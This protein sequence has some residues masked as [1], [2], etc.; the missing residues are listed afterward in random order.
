M[1]DQLAALDCAPYRG[2]APNPRTL[3][4]VFP[5]EAIWSLGIA[6]HYG[7]ADS[8]SVRSYKAK[9]PGTVAATESRRLAQLPLSG[10]VPVLVDGGMPGPAAETWVAPL[11]EHA[12]RVA[13]RP[14]GTVGKGKRF[15]DVIDSGLAFA[16][17]VPIHPPPHLYREDTIKR[18]QEKLQALL[19]AEDRTVAKSYLTLLVDHIVVDD[20][21]ITVVAKTEGALRRLA[22]GST[23]DGELTAAVVSP[24][25]VMPWLG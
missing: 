4:E 7:G 11:A 13:T 9:R 20:T 23:T 3:L 2:R 6:G 25:T 14:N 12:C 10:F 8:A 17:V 19:V 22:T 5:S 18:F 21:D 24:T 1:V 15:D 16:Q